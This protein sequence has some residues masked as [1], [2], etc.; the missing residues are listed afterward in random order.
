MESKHSV[1]LSELLEALSQDLSAEE[2]LSAKVLAQISTQLSSERIKRGMSQ[3][4]FA[5]FMGTTQ[6]VISKWENSDRNFTIKK[7][8]E[9]A[10][11]LN[12]DLSVKLEKMNQAL[13]PPN[14]VIQFPSDY[15]V[16]NSPSPNWNQYFCP[17]NEAKEN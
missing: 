16:G 4:E 11:K 7:L 3:A 2:I 10:C 14:N 5:E 6:T 12:C 15:I 13:E 8:C 9:I 1:P 17:E